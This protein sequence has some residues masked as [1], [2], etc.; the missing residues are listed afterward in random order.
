MQL[1]IFNLPEV[2]GSREIFL[3]HTLWFNL[4]IH[5]TTKI[6][7]NI[8]EL[9]WG[10]VE[11][12]SVK[13]GLDDNPVINIQHNPSGNIQPINIGKQH[14]KPL[15]PLII[16]HL[17][18]IH[19]LDK[20][21]AWT[22]HPINFSSREVYSWIIYPTRAGLFLSMIL[23]ERC[24]RIATPSPL[25]TPTPLLGII[26][27]S[28]LDRTRQKQSPGNVIWYF[29]GKLSIAVQYFSSFRGCVLAVIYCLSGR[30]SGW[31]REANRHA[32]S[33]WGIY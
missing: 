14:P 29:I 18:D 19:V 4:L 25:N 7:W 1:T 12:G 24:H 11:V 20:D 9:S 2:R 22:A 31:N 8:K 16:Q 27:Q 26:I 6:T 32:R 3:K 10:S 28:W 13:Y 15:E 30:W 23:E 33:A 17:I 21:A 5:D